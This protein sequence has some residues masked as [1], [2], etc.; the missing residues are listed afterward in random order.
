M[1]IDEKSKVIKKCFRKYFKD[2]YGKEW[3]ECKEWFIVNYVLNCLSIS[4]NE[5]IEYEVI[6]LLII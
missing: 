6:I 5:F 4:M 2:K 3:W 1:E